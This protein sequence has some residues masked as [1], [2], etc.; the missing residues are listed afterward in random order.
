MNGKKH[1]GDIEFLLTEY[2][3]GNL[4]AAGKAELATRLESD[5]ELR[6]ELRRYTALNENLQIPPQFDDVLDEIDY[7]TQRAEIIAAVERKVLL[8]G[9]PRR[10]LLLRPTFRV[11]AAAATVLLVFAVGAFV[12][13]STPQMLEVA[14]APSQVSSGG[15][16]EFELVRQDAPMMAAAMPAGTI[17]VSVGGASSARQPT[18]TFGFFN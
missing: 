8:E 11:L 9:L 2:L 4:D 3:D 12:F 18:G 14:I 16:L 17:V 5:A 10:R 7:D 15:A 1:N 13:R 6:Q